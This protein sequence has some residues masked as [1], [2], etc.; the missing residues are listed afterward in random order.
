MKSQLSTST[1]GSMLPGIEP[2]HDCDPL[3]PAK[4]LGK[5]FEAC[6]EDRGKQLNAAGIASI[7]RYGTTAVH[8]MNYKTRQ[9][10]LRAIPSKPD[11]EGVNHEGRQF[12]F[13]CKVCSAS[14]FDLQDYRSAAKGSRSRQLR[15]MLERAAFG[16]PCFFLIH[17]NRR[18]LITK[19]VPQQTWAV[20]VR[21][22]DPYWE[23]VEDGT[24]SSL[25]RDDCATLGK[26]VRWFIPPKCRNAVPDLHDAVGILRR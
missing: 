16:V 18:E 8:M 1:S 23:A 2:E 13:D 6:V 3:I 22:N 17:W 12:I 26:S 14:K 10:E 25:T 5:E 21:A 20:Y 19:K 7:G 15:W 24:I 11:F 9:L 4:L